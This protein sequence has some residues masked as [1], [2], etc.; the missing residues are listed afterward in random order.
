VTAF[1]V[2]AAQYPVEPLRGFSDYAAK[3]ERWVA[4]AQAGGARLAVFPEYGGME[5]TALDPETVGDLHA[6]I[7]AL[8]ALV[9]RVDA[10]HAALATRYDLHICAASLPVREADG[11]FRNHARLFAPGGRWGTQRKLVMTRFEREEWGI[12]AG[13]SLNVFDT[14]LGRIGIAICY[15][16]EFP[17]L[18][19][20]QAEAG[21]TLIL[22]PS[23]TDSMHGFH[24]VRVGARAR[25][26]EN[27]CHV[28]QAPVVGEAGWTPSLDVSHGAAGIFGP[29]D[30]GFPDDGIIAQGEI[31]QPGWVFGKVDPA[32][33]E[34]VRRTGAVFNHALWAE[35]GASVALPPVRIVDLRG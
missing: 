3:I 5:L 15:D 22:A 21:A 24:R 1:L 33:V 7:A 26:L 25:A 19:R 16:V 18:V 35:Q 6:S 28:V 29:P 17:L 30:L 34:R 23:A 20:A 4:E 31:D 12:A 13:T 9:E 32:A 11:R 8:G 10:L 2:A 27:Q 14:D